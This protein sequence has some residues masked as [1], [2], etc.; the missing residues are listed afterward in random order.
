MSNEAEKY[1]AIFELI[2]IVSKLN[3][4]SEI[5]RIITT[6]IT[7]MFDTDVTTIKMINPKTEDTCRTIFNKER[8]I[9]M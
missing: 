6:K 8:K 4:F 9:K 1:D 5:L 3:D 7:I 2:K